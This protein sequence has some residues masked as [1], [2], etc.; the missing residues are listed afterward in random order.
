[1]KVIYKYRLDITDCQN[2]LLPKDS[3][4]LS[5]KMQHGTMCLWA[6]VD[7]SNPVEYQEFYVIGTGNPIPEK[8]IKNANFL[9]TVLDGSF[10]WHVFVKK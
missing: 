6:L 1:M 3:A 4:L 5:V 8:V 10:V 7:T 2:I 9:S